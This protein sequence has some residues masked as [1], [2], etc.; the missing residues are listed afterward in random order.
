MICVLFIGRYR[1][2]TMDR[3]L[4]LMAQTQELLIRQ[5]RPSV[6]RDPLISVTQES[7]SQPAL[8]Q[9]A[10]PLIGRPDDPHRALYRTLDFG[11]RSFRPHLIH[12]EEE[13]DSLAAL[14]IALARRWFAP[15][16]KL[17]L[18]TWQ[19]IDRPRAWPVR[20]VTS[21]TL[22][23]ADAVLCANREAEAILKRKGY[24][25][26]TQVL[27]AIGVDTQTFGPCF[28]R[29]SEGP[30]TIGYVGRLV[31]EKGIE[32]LIDA[33][34]MLGSE[35]RLIIIG[36][37]PHRRALEERVR[38]VGLGERARFDPP[39]PP[40]EIA[41]RLCE[42]DVLVLPS[43]TTYVWK[44]QFGRVLIEAMACKV[45]VIGSDSG[46]IPEVI[47]DAGLIFPEGNAQALAVC[48]QRLIASPELRQ[49]LA[50]R[51]YL[52]A[53]TLYSQERI[54]RHTADFYQI[55]LGER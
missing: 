35:A 14:Q 42:L 46:A 5:I 29:L 43:R 9:V 33:T 28:A 25:G 12:A 55:M 17:I 2:P 38:K 13:P 53:T 1:D 20:L 24:R 49:E 45:P 41:R 48:L 31:P 52:R 6:W 8:E 11:M 21:L 22:R 3:K 37:G 50:E 36:G 32:T 23:A 47:G 40:S 7:V 54:A 26:L 39:V 27:P 10:I 16:A 18:Y 51:G 44:E 19:N 15:Q 34:A 30:F 4:V